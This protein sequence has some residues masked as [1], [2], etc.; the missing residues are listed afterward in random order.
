MINGIKY[1]QHFILSTALIIIVTTGVFGLNS[2][3][4]PNNK[5]KSL[6]MQLASGE[7]SSL[8]NAVAWIN[9]PSL[10]APELKGKVVLIQFCTYTCINWIRTLPYVRAWSTKYSDQGLVV[11][12]VH[13]PE[14]TFEKN[15]DNVRLAMREMNIE[16]PIA[17]DNNYQIWE[18]FSNQYWPAIYL[19]D[20]KGRI[21]HHQSG[22][23]GYEEMEKMIQKLLTDS[24]AKDTGHD[25]IS[26]NG[27]GIE[28][29][30]DWGNLNSQENYLGYERTENFSSRGGK[31]SGASTY[32]LPANLRLNQWAL[33]GEWTMEKKSVLLNNVNGKIVF[34]FHA[35]DLHL[36]MG[37]VSS[38]ARIRFR[39]LIDGKPPGADHG[40]DI[41][42]QGFGSMGEQRLYQLIRQTASIIDRTFQIE[43]LDAG[44]EAFSVTFG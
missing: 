7:L 20:K 14:F 18:G 5:S 19:V 17:I 26:V 29:A 13:T 6:N 39:V 15:I 34:R 4:T 3:K 35:R 2:L 44:A 36:V 27:D 31:V 9:S 24:G 42:E 12:G 1:V 30:A 10:T 38:E 28:A 33:A 43:F 41:D 16:F 21:A 8:K 11:I 22:E 37:P 40:T 32:H 23:G 25:L